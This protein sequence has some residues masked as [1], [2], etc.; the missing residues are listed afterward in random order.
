MSRTFK[1][2]DKTDCSKF[3]PEQWFGCADAIIH[4]I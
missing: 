3:N 1:A 4:I 2:K